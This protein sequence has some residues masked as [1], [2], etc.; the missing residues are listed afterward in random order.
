MTKLNLKKYKTYW[1]ISAIF[2]IAQRFSIFFFGFVSFLVLVRTL[3]P[4]QIGTWSLFLAITTTFE[5]IKTGLLKNS[6]VILFNSTNSDEQRS[7]LSSSSLIMN[8]AVTLLFIILCFAGAHALS[9]YWKAPALD[10]MLYYYCLSSLVFIPFSHFEYL[11]QANMTFKGIFM[12][13]FVRQLIFFLLIVIF[14]IAFESKLTL[15]ALVIFQIIGM[16]IA[17]VVSFLY[18]RKYLLYRF[19]PSP[20]SIK[21]IFHYGKYVFGSGV[22]SNLFGSMDRY[23]SASLLNSVVVAYYDIGSRINNMLDIPTRAAADIIFPKSSRASFEE[24]NHKVRYMFEKISAILG[25]LVLPASIFIFIFAEW[26]I[27]I[28]AGDKYLA[29]A[30]IIRVAMIYATLRPIQN[31]A[32][33]IMDSINKPNITFKLNVFV[34]ACNLIFN[35]VCIRMFGMMGAA[36]GTLLTTVI[37][38]GITLYLLNRIIGSKVSSIIKNV[39]DIY[40]SAFS[41]VFFVLNPKKEAV[42]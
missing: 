21:E 17:T 26:I 14:V 24:G 37:S 31:Q 39:L 29:A 13:Y 42:Q 34:L 27:K 11:Q 4:A 23:M 1:Y 32:A 16:A 38:F 7:S 12:A 33:N 28:I 18:S 41:K 10:T 8:V 15:P 3:S 35:Y 9:E 25:A 20:K 5:L 2:T 36:Y 19:N 30:A 22:C 40:I 6:F